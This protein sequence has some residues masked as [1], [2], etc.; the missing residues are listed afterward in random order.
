M[1]PAH[2]VLYNNG[3]S[4]GVVAIIISVYTCLEV[5]TL[6]NL[7]MVDLSAKVNCSIP[8]VFEIKPMTTALVYGLTPSKIQRIIVHAFSMK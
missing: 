7:N 3:Q 8:V 2:I 6:H 1:V 4:M 5:F